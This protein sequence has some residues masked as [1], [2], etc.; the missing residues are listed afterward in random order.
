[1]IKKE[2]DMDSLQERNLLSECDFI[3][4]RSSGAGGQNVNKVNTKVE[5]RFQIKQSHILD[6]DEK[7]ILLSKLGKRISGEGFL[8]IQSQETRSQLKNKE[9]AIKKFFAIL[10][11]TLKPRKKR[12]KT[13]P[14][15]TSRQKR[16]DDKRLHSEKK[17]LRKNPDT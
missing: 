11:K 13:R 17:S 10:K 4:S 16:L 3:T 9:E 5:L 6:E 12:K 7:Q 2:I 8:I 1:M 15:L 14:S